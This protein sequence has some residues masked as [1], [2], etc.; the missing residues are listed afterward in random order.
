MFGMGK[1]KRYNAAIDIKLSLEYQIVTKGNSKFPGAIAYLK[2]IDN[3]WQTKMSEDEGA[4]YIAVLYYSG[5]LKK[6]AHSEAEPLFTRIVS[7]AGF[8][9][10]KGMISQER[11]D[12][13]KEA[14]D[15]AR[16]SAGINNKRHA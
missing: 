9:L 1:R 3:A 15:D 14:I 13:F 8:G 11:W 7:I 10:P 16:S 4:L 5:L 12:K 6:G 2:L